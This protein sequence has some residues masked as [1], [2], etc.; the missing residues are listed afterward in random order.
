MDTAILAQYP[1]WYVK[2]PSWTDLPCPAQLKWD[3]SYWMVENTSM[4]LS[5]MYCEPRWKGKPFVTQIHVPFFCLSLIDL[6]TQNPHSSNERSLFQI[7]WLQMKTKGNHFR[8]VNH[9]PCLPADMETIFH[10]CQY[11]LDLWNQ[12]SIDI[13]LIS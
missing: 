9:F 2:F 4:F 1:I 10:V 13:I 5:I 7:W 6:Q 3:R 12:K 8:H 11:M